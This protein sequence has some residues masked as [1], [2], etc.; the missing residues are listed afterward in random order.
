MNRILRIVTLLFIVMLTLP[1]LPQTVSAQTNPP[2]IKVKDGTSTNWS[3]YAVQTN[4]QSPQRDAVTDVKGQWQVPQ[5][6]C[7]AGNTYSSVWVGIDG[8]SDGTVE[9]TGTEQDCSGGQAK[10]SAWY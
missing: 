8:Y 5:V 2:R 3:G 10:Y 4:L 9:Q 6:S 1:T 7:G